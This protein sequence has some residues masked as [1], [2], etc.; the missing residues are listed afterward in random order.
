MIFINLNAPFLQWTL[1]PENATNPVIWTVMD[2][3][4]NEVIRMGGFGQLEDVAEIFLKLAQVHQL[5]TRQV[6]PDN[7]NSEHIA[8]A[9]GEYEF[10]IL[11]ES[12]GTVIFS[13][14]DSGRIAYEC[15]QKF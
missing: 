3:I 14:D 12:N 5:N 9:A 2:C 4:D 8:L 11:I 10:A 7:D 15:E 1:V 6:E 13:H